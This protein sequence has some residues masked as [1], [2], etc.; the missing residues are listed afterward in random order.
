MEWNVD[1][2]IGVVGIGAGIVLAAIAIGVGLGMDTRTQGELRFV[3]GCFIFSALA[4]FLPVV[5]WAIHTDLAPLKRWGIVGIASLLIGVCLVEGLRW[6]TGRHATEITTTVPPP[7]RQPPP[8]NTLLLHG[9]PT[10]RQLFENGWPNLPA[11][12][13]KTAIQFTEP[14][15]P[16]QVTVFWRLNGDF[17]ARS[18]FFDLY[19][20]ESTPSNHVVD[21]CKAIANFYQELIDEANHHVD[22]SGRAP[23]DTSPTHMKDMVFSKRLRGSGVLTTSK[24]HH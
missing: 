4:L 6:A 13:N 15:P 8:V 11:Y 22:I 21:A 17:F 14:K 7:Q 18:K 19:F 10:L 23:D 16:H 24:E 3:Q 2:I 1:R 9:P 12:Y 5:F 20:E